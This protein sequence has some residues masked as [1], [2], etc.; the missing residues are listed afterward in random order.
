MDRVLTII[1]SPYRATAEHSVS[2]H[3]EYLYRCMR[4]SALVRGEAPFASHEF[5]TRALD[6]ND[7]VERLAGMECG[8]AWARQAE[9]VAWYLDFGMSE[10][11]LAHLRALVER[12][13]LAAP[14]PDLRVRSLDHPV[15]WL[16]W[17]LATLPEGMGLALRVDAR[18]P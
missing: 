16:E 9:R 7:P 8:W 3:I 6:D 13:R 18:K 2:E 1:E 15:E 10:G 5:Y 14:T 4:D 11:M 12:R 17:Q